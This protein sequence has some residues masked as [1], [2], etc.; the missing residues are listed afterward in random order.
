[1]H[2]YVS[3]QFPAALGIAASIRVGNEA[4]A[5]NDKGV[6]TATFVAIGNICELNI[7]FYQSQCV[8]CSLYMEGSSM[9][10]S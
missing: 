9:D 1:M 7:T 6:S 2:Y 5:G 4:G 3:V 8:C 10:K